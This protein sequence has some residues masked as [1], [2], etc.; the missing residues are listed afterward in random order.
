MDYYYFITM[1]PA[2]KQKSM[3]CKETADIVGITG[4]KKTMK[5]SKQSRF[6]ENIL[7]VRSKQCSILYMYIKSV[8]ISK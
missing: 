2:L 6:H 3:T 5:K 7:I 1:F 8:Y 4:D